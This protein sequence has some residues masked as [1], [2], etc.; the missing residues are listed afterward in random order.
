MSML[1]ERLARPPDDHYILPKLPNSTL[2]GNGT[3][4]GDHGGGQGGRGGGGGHRGG[5]RPTRSHW[6]YSRYLNA[7]CLA[8]V[9]LI[10][11]R[12]LLIVLAHRRAIRR[13]ARPSPRKRAVTRWRNALTAATQSYAKLRG[14]PAWLY[15]PENWADAAVTIVYCGLLFFY[16]F[17]KTRWFGGDQNTAN[18]MGVMAFSQLPLIIV[19]ITKHNPVTALTGITYQ[20]LFYLHRAASR[21]CLAL[22]WAHTI[23]WTPDVWEA[24]H[25]SHAYILWGIAAILGFTGLYVT[26]F[27]V[28]RRV[29]YE[30]FIVSHII[31]TFMFLLG[32]VF[33]WYRLMYW[34][35][36]AIAIYVLDRVVSGV[37][38][39][40]NNKLA[41]FS[42]HHA[43]GVRETLEVVDVELI[44][45]TLKRP[46]TWG[47]G[48]HFFLSAPS[49]Q[50][51]VHE[52]HPFSIANIPESNG[53]EAIFLIRVHT[54]FTKRLHEYL[55]TREAELSSSMS[56]I[57]PG[58]PRSVLTTSSSST[59][60]H[61][62]L[63]LLDG[64]Y[65]PR[66]SLAAYASVL[67]VAG[68]TGVTY[69]SSH[70]LHVLHCLRTGAAATRTVRL[71]WHVR[72]RAHV[73]WLAPILE[74]AADMVRD[75]RASGQNGTGPK[76][77]LDIDVYVTRTHV[78]DE[79]A[80]AP[81]LAA[82]V[83]GVNLSEPP[84]PGVRTPFEEVEEV[85]A[86]GTFGAPGSAASDATLWHRDGYGGAYPQPGAK[87]AKRAPSL[88]DDP[89]DETSPL[90]KPARASP[91][92]ELGLS[93][94][95]LALLSFHP[96]RADVT[97]I[98]EDM[99]GVAE[100]TVNVSVCGPTEL[101]RA[102]RA[103][104]R[105]ADTARNALRGGERVDYY[106]ETLG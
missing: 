68:G 66:E 10:A 57:A 25:F 37:R 61:K 89:V 83:L 84:T 48:Q 62:P 12:H 101:M 16:A 14:F 80:P 44:R 39:L 63:F 59:A 103:A 43:E 15:G 54:G 32:A 67:L 105:D 70:L 50:Q 95:A 51:L 35:W 76:F 21:A 102:A 42:R 27:R 20:K 91:V 60:E 74:A 106:E 9:L 11:A 46:V 26:S 6:Y 40:R 1:Y 94:D 34:V 2:P 90:L 78:A 100:G 72:H 36:P 65:G 31:F 81:G 98:L 64:P 30:F 7:I 69:V 87:G 47:P 38:T 22:S 8:V 33:H 73:A 18:Q 28:I 56:T 13:R 49:V 45:V 3:D 52:R 99:V 55:S 92:G 53:G 24:G 104:V 96:G 79:P 75:L 93:A 17:N 58:S 88:P 23:A 71:V 19:L 41:S 77:E 85:D 86:L 5:A 4:R 97:A 29:A 82:T